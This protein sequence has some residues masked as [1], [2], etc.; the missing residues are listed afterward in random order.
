ML[1]YR[2]S[3]VV[4]GAQFAYWHDVICRHFVPAESW[5]DKPSAFPASFATSPLGS[6]QISR[7]SAPRHSWS[8]T[9][10]NLRRAPRDE[11]LLSLKLSGT[12]CLGQAGREAVQQ[13]G[14]LA[15]YDTGRP[16]SYLLDSDILLLKIPR[17]ELL[18]RLPRVSHYTARTFGHA[19]PVGQLAAR[20]VRDAHQLDLAANPAAAE[21][22]GHCLVDA[23]VAAMEWELGGAAAPGRGHTALLEAVKAY[24]L[25]HL[26]NRGLDSAT[27]AAR[28]GISV[29]TL[30]RLFAAHGTTPMRWLWSQRLEACRR[31][32][33]TDRRRTIT[34]I[35]FRFGFA[36]ASHFSRAFK[37]AY[38]ITPSELSNNREV[39][40]CD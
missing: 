10:E 16:F 25:S 30:N 15:L 31:A 26:G 12:T 6:F 13:P 1:V 33:A 37:A 32:L 21:Q 19:S 20:L 39:G 5:L 8:R 17:H 2:T 7:L 23:V 40:Q 29:R 4:E 38:Y 24:A 27:L 11:F 34:E 14:E 9:E 28:H 18:T 3:A 22:M 36:D 35:A